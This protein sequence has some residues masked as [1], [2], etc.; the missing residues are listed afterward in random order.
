MTPKLRCSSSFKGIDQPPAEVSMTILVS[1]C[2]GGFLGFRFEV[3]VV[4]FEFEIWIRLLCSMLLICLEVGLWPYPEWILK[5]S[6][7]LDHIYG[8]LTW[9]STTPSEQHPLDHHYLL[10]TPSTFYHQALCQ[11]YSSYP[12]HSQATVA[13]SCFHSSHAL[14][15]LESLTVLPSWIRALYSISTLWMRHLYTTN[16]WAT[17]ALTS[18]CSALLEQCLAQSRARKPDCAYLSPRL[19]K[20]VTGWWLLGDFLGKHLRHELLSR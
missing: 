2:A 17:K 1:L 3:F 14:M 13:K 12:S 4:R 16:S 7:L 15:P 20:T 9:L 11:P 8:S 5:E 6:K 10:K 18:H 19:V